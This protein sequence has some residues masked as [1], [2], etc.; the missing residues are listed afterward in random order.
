MDVGERDLQQCADAII[1]L[2]A[3]YLRQAGRFEEIHFNFT[4]GHRADYVKWREGYRPV[5]S[6][7]SVRW[8]KRDQRD[9]RYAGFRGYLDKV[10]EYA[11]TQ[12]LSRELSPVNDVREVAIGDVFIRGG[13]PGHAVIVVNVAE[14]E[15]GRR[16]LF[17]LAQSYMPAQDIHVLRNPNDPDLS[18]WY[19]VDFGQELLTPEYTFRRGELRRF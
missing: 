14:S 6:G 18:P 10:F 16:R 5:V 2:R 4:S 9:E 12:S 1:R 7:N 11:G 3:E 13:F 17:L 19:D 15:G 8:E